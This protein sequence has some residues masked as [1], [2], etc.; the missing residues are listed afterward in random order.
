MCEGAGE[1]WKA[2]AMT[3][4]KQYTYSN[5]YLIWFEIDYKYELIHSIIIAD[6]KFSINF[7]GA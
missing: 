2:L 6:Y 1:L 7:N 5:T 4:N 3:L